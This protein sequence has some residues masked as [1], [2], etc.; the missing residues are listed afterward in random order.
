[1]VLRAANTMRHIIE[2]LCATKIPQDTFIQSLSQNKIP[3]PFIMF[4]SIWSFGVESLICGSKKLMEVGLF[5]DDLAKENKIIFPYGC[6]CFDVQVN[7]DTEVFTPWS[8]VK[9]N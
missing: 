1:M 9:N 2:G 8:D 5:F 3:L 6:G 4:A 7:V